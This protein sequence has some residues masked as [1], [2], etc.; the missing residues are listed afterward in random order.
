MK[1]KE[2]GKK[3]GD[4]YH[5]HHHHRYLDQIVKLTQIQL[6]HRQDTLRIIEN[7]AFFFMICT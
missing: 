5:H 1:R 2:E 4:D 7:I 3:E 6:D